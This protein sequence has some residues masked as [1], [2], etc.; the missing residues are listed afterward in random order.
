MNHLIPEKLEHNCSPLRYKKFK[1]EFMIWIE[2]SHPAGYSQEV[3]VQLLFNRLD[4][5]WEDRL[6]NLG[7]TASEKTI[8]SKMD[9]QMLNSHL[10]HNRLSG[11][12]TQN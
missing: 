9:Q 8:W 2:N 7:S 5:N 10:I 6:G 12:L 3:F 4:S 11:L 1:K